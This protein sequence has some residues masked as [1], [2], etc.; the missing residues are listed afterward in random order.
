MEEFLL[1]FTIASALGKDRGPTTVQDTLNTDAAL[2]ALTRKRDFVQREHWFG[3][4]STHAAP[5]PCS[6]ATQTR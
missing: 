5:I 2:L 4:F 6:P 3:L 1:L